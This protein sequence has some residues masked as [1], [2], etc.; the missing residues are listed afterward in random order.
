[1]AVTPTVINSDDQIYLVG[2]PVN[3]RINNLNKDATIASVVCELYI[4]R[5]NLNEPPT[6]ASYT[7]K[8]S[9]VSQSDNYIN[10]QISEQISSE[11]TRTRFSW[12]SGN[13]EP[14]ISGE[15]VFFQLK[16]VVTNENGTVETPV[17]SLTNFATNGYRE[18]SEQIGD[19]AGD[20]YQQPYIGLKPINYN[21]NYESR[22]SYYKRSFDYTKTL[23]NCTS[24]NMVTSVP[25]VP[26]KTVCQLGDKTLIVYINRWGLWDYFTPYGKFTKSLKIKAETNVRLYRNPRSINNSINHSTRRFLEKTEQSYTINTGD[27]TEAMVSQVEELI[28]SPLVYLLEFTGEVF[29]VVNLGVTVDNTIITVDSTLYTVDNQTVTEIDLG[30]FST[31]KQI[32]VTNDNN[33]FIFKTR[34]NDKSKINYDLEFMGTTDKINN[35]R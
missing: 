18:D 29:T 27:L 12:T 32:P 13:S 25:N 8:S 19:T 11:I 21:R 24:E 22:I 1:M 14:L 3:I 26:T 10:F 15:G 33:D 16:H 20:L 5:G 28:F 7:L 23:V 6:T 9:K 34:L 2:S 17:E 4:W 30:Y 35:I 31:F